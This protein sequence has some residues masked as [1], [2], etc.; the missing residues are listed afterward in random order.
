MDKGV[1]IKEK[2]EFKDIDIQTVAEEIC[3]CKE[4]CKTYNADLKKR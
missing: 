3:I 1:Q 4:E 2:K